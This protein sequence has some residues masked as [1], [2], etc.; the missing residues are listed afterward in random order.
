MSGAQGGGAGQGGQENSYGLLWVIFGTLT[1][2]F[3]I[4]YFFKLYILIALVWIKYGEILAIQFFAD[5][6]TTTAWLEWIK[7]VKIML[8][9]GDTSALTLYSIGQLCEF[10]GYYLKFPL[11]LILAL[12][13]F[14][15]YRGHSGVRFN[16]IYNMNSLADQE[17]NNWPQI[18]PIVDLD[19]VEE[20]INEGPWAIAQN[21]MQ[22]AK[23]NKLI[24]LEV[25]PDPKATWRGGG[26]IMARVIKP[27]CN[28]Y[29]AAQLGPLYSGYKNLPPHTKAL[30]G[31]F[32][33]RTLHK[34]DEAR[35]YLK[36]LSISAAKG[37]IDYS[38]TNEFLNKYAKGNKVV[39]K[40]EQNHAYVLTI[41]AEMLELARLDGVFAVADFLWLKPL[42]RRLW[43]MLNSV[44]RQVAVPEVAGP[45]A[46]WLAEKEMGKPLNVPMV[47]EATTGLE[48]AL[49]A[50]IYQPDD[51]EEIQQD[52]EP[53]PTPGQGG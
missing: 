19:L 31:I 52:A 7:A 16:K 53:A 50:M 29:F 6:A 5:N 40:C 28:R 20:N 48:K 51:G 8:N 38:L 33:A 21:P 25:I 44:G 30:F 1:A 39:Q 23:Q 24:E 27:K 22:F 47:E 42:D 15:L 2:G 26:T 12:L 45:F 14:S 35:A 37:D 18:S 13:C 49:E 46:H 17:K 9:A 36:Q 41:M 11:C 10:T 4:W 43:F 32:C 34:A 3:L